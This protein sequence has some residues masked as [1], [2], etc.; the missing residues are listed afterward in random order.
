[1]VALAEGKDRTATAVVRTTDA[2]ASAAPPPDVRPTELDGRV[3]HSADLH[4]AEAVQLAVRMPDVDQ[5]IKIASASHA[6]LD[7]IQPPL[8]LEHTLV[9]WAS[10]FDK[11]QAPSGTNHTIEFS[12][13]GDGIRILHN[14]HVDNAASTESSPNESNWP[15]S[16]TNSADTG[17][18]A[19]RADAKS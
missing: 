16:P 7:R 8:P 6:P 11:I 9:G 13:C 15:S 1:M 18:A 17:L 19:M 12:H 3:L 5:T 4:A 2:S 10:V 14:V